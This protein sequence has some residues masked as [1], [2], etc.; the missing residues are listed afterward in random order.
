MAIDQTVTN[1]ARVTDP[2]QPQLFG[3]LTVNATLVTMQTS[4]AVTKNTQVISVVDSSPVAGGD[5]VITVPG[6]GAAGIDQPVALWGRDLQAA[7]QLACNNQVI[8]TANAT[9]PLTLTVWDKIP[10]DGRYVRFLARRRDNGDSIEWNYGLPMGVLITVAG[11]VY[12]LTSNKH[13]FAVPG[14]LHLL[15]GLLTPGVWD[16]AFTF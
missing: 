7:N 13:C 9:V 3:T 8:V 16:Y 5:D 11:G 15:P 14:K 2:L 6:T 12:A 4:A 10:C 1:F